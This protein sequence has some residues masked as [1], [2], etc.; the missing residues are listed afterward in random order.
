M[1]VY[2]TCLCKHK[3]KQHKNQSNGR[4]HHQQKPLAFQKICHTVHINLEG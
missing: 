3:L 2:E 4:Q 1:K